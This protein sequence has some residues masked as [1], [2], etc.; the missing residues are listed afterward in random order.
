MQ[1]KAGDFRII[2]APNGL[3]QFQ[4]LDD[5]RSKE[6]RPNRQKESPWEDVGQPKE[7]SEALGLLSAREVDAVA[8]RELLNVTATQNG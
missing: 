7:Y 4:R 2:S 1:T 6:D 3:W 5:P 8:R